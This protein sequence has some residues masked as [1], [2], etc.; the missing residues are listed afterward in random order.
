MSSMSLALTDS[1]TMLRRNLLRMRRYPSMTLLLIGL[2]ILMLLLFVY[3]FGGTLGAGI[4]DD[5]VDYLTPGILLFTVVGVMAPGFQ[6]PNDTD[7]WHRLTWDEAQHSRGA[8]FMESVARLKPGATID[9]AATINLRMF[10]PVSFLR[11]AN[12]PL[13]TSYSA[14]P[15]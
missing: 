3:V 10:P 9:A 1:S 11:S 6:Y 13:R 15:I 14:A 4:G 12:T 2:P 5:Y 8:H 7:V